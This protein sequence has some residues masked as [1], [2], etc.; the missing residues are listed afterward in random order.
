MKEVIKNAQLR[1]V[2]HTDMSLEKFYLG[3]EQGDDGGAGWY[4]HWYLVVPSGGFRKEVYLALIDDLFTAGN[5]SGRV[6]PSKT[7]K[8]LIDQVSDKMKIFEFDTFFE[9]CTFYINDP[10]AIKTTKS[11]SSNHV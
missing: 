9:L 2:P 5:T 11:K 4:K 8:E 7:L 10:N 3:F 1:T 6:Q